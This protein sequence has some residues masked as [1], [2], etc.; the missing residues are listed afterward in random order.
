MP[1]PKAARKKRNCLAEEFKQSTQSN[2]STTQV[3]LK[4]SGCLKPKTQGEFGSSKTCKDCRRKVMDKFYSKNPNY[5]VNRRITRYG[6][7]PERYHEM[8][9]E[10]NFVCKICKMPPTR[11]HASKGDKLPR[12]TID[13]NHETGEVR[14]LV[15]SRCNFLIGYIESSGQKV[16]QEV[17]YY[18]RRQNE[19]T[20]N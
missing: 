10:Q 3:T 6:I 17:I 16:V 7:T 13:H 20:R 18:L 19:K 15:C 8:E 5:K 9:V 11:H 14:G 4:C 12:L 1:R 2:L